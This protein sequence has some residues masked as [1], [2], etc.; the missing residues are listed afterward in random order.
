MNKETRGFFTP[1]YVKKYDNWLIF[2]LSFLYICWDLL[3][4]GTGIS[5]LIFTILFC[6]FV[7]VRLN[8]DGRITPE[9]KKA[10]LPW[11]LVIVLSAIASAWFDY[12]PLGWF[13]FLFLTA[14]VLYWLAVLTGTRILPEVSSY[15]PLDLLIQLVKLPF[16]NF[17]RFFSCIFR[18]RI[19]CTETSEHDSSSKSGFAGDNSTVLVKRRTLLRSGIQILLTLCMITPLLL[20]VLNLLAAADESFMRMIAHMIDDFFSIFT[21]TFSFNMIETIGH[22]LL[23]IPVSA[24]LFGLLWAHTHPD[25]A[26]G[27]GSKEITDRWLLSLHFVPGIMILTTLLTFTMIYLLFL[28]LQASHLL[29]ALNH[30]LPET[31]TYSQFAREGFF[32]LCAVAF[33]N[34]MILIGVWL[35]SKRTVNFEVPRNLRLM[36]SLL[37]IQTIL[38]VVTAMVKMGLYIQVYGLTRLRAYTFWFMI[39]LLLVFIILTLATARKRGIAAGTK[40]TPAKCLTALTVSMFLALNYLNVDALIVRDH[41]T[42]AQKAPLSAETIDDGYLWSLSGNARLALLDYYGDD[43]PEERIPHGY[44]DGGDWRRATITSFRLNSHLKDQ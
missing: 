38:L 22:L 34:L 28:G 35:L 29:E 37:S 2:L 7:Y 27:F 42:R 1:C 33:I 11:F 3:W 16:S 32:E 8:L 13:N 39:W 5:V 12:T 43:I 23:A 21:H 10:S 6:G 18:T 44:W 14:S 25:Q 40:L 19:S 26:K 4:N 30:G 24:Y 41:I 9:N 15:L 36:L 17:S 20:I 31:T